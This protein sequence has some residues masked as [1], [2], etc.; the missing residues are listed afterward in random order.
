MTLPV[1]ATS[2]PLTGLDSFIQAVDSRSLSALVARHHDASESQVRSVVLDYGRALFSE[3]DSTPATD[4]ISPLCPVYL[5][6]GELCHVILMQAGISDL[7]LPPGKH[8][9]P[10]S[11]GSSILQC[12]SI[13]TTTNSTSPSPGYLQLETSVAN[14]LRTLVPNA[15]SK[16]LIFIPLCHARHWGLIV[17]TL[18]MGDNARVRA[19]VQW[20]DSLRRGAPPGVLHVVQS[21]VKKAYSISLC[22][23]D[24]TVDYMLDVHKF[25]QQTDSFASGFYVIAL[26]SMIAYSTRYIPRRS[27]HTYNLE[28]IEDIRDACTA[29]LLHHMYALHLQRPSDAC[30]VRHRDVFEYLLRCGVDCHQ[31]AR[32]RPQGNVSLSN[33]E[34]YNA[35]SLQ[36]PENADSIHFVSK[37][38]LSAADVPHNPVV[39]QDAENPDHSD[40]T[41]N[42]NTI[43]DSG[44]HD[45]DVADAANEP[46]PTDAADDIDG[47]GDADGGG[48]VDDGEKPKVTELVHDIVNHYQRLASQGFFFGNTSHQ[49]LKGRSGRG[50]LYRAYIQLRCIKYPG[51]RRRNIP[52]CKAKLRYDKLRESDGWH[53]S[54]F[55]EHSHPPLPEKL[56]SRR[57]N[58]VIQTLKDVQMWYLPRHLLPRPVPSPSN[59][60]EKSGED[61][62]PKAAE[63]ILPRP[64]HIIPNGQ[65]VRPIL[66]SHIHPSEPRPSVPAIQSHPGPQNIATQPSCT[67]LASQLPTHTIQSQHHPPRAV[68][69]PSAHLAPHLTSQPILTV[70]HS[71][72]LH[73]IHQPQSQSPHQV[74]ISSPHQ[75]RSAVPIAPRE[76]MHPS[77]FVHGIQM[78]TG[79]PH[80]TA[81]HPSQMVSHPIA[82]ISNNAQLPLNG[83]IVSLPQSTPNLNGSIPGSDLSGFHNSNTPNLIPVHPSGR[84]HPGKD[85]GQNPNL[86]NIS[87]D[88]QGL[89][90]VDGTDADGEITAAEGANEV[91][92]ESIPEPMDDI[93][94]LS[95]EDLVPLRDGGASLALVEAI[96]AYV[97]TAHVKLAENEMAQH[98]KKIAEQCG[99]KLRIRRSMYHAGQENVFIKSATFECAH[100]VR[101]GC[102]FAFR[103][104]G[105]LKRRRS[106]DSSGG[107]SRSDDEEDAL[108]SQK[109][110]AVYTTTVQFLNQTHNHEH[111]HSLL[112]KHIRQPDLPKTPIRLARADGLTVGN[113]I[114]YVEKKHSF[115]VPRTPLRK[116]IISERHIKDPLAQQCN[117]L[118]SR[119]MTI[120]NELSNTFVHFAPEGRR[121]TL[122]RL[123]WSFPEWQDDYMRYGRVPGVY[124]DTA[125]LAEQLKLPLVAIN[126]RTNEGDTVTFFV[127]FIAEKS[128]ES[129]SWM[130]EQFKQCMS[131]GEAFSP[132]VVVVEDCQATITAVRKHFSSS[133]VFMDTCS[134]ATKEKENV[135]KFLANLDMSHLYEQ[136]SSRLSLLRGCRTHDDFMITRKSF[137]STFFSKLDGSNEQPSWYKR[138]YYD[139]KELVVY[140]FNRTCCGLRFL[141]D[142]ADRTRRFD[143]LHKL[144]VDK[145]LAES[146]EIPEL[147]R[148][149]VSARKEAEAAK[150]REIDTD[151]VRALSDLKL[152]GNVNSDQC[153]LQLAQ[154]FTGFCIQYLRKSCLHLSD[155]WEVRSCRAEI[156]R[157]GQ[158]QNIK[159]ASFQVVRS[160]DAIN[161]DEVSLANYDREV[162]VSR[163]NNSESV[164]F[165]FLCSCGFSKMNGLPCAH[166]LIVFRTFND[167]TN[168]DVKAVRTHLGTTSLP[169]SSFIHEY[170]KRD[171]SGWMDMISAVRNESRGNQQADEYSDDRVASTSRIRAT[172]QARKQEWQT[173]LTYVGNKAVFD[174]AWAAVEVL[175]QDKKEMFHSTLWQLVALCRQRRVPDAKK[176]A[177]ACRSN[178]VGR[179][180]TGGGALDNLIGMRDGSAETSEVGRGEKRVLSNG[181][182]SLP[183]RRRIDNENVDGSS[184]TDFG[185]FGPSGIFQNEL[186]RLEDEGG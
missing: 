10:P 18:V 67:P 59:G 114:R 26:L 170:W 127:S 181:L 103:L 54:L 34:A 14:S 45:D 123:C 25:A 141:F 121:K 146:C 150:R 46:E 134:L 172:L 71:Q 138:L 43:S 56:R 93:F 2:A 13:D 129:F 167:E 74:P 39:P 16:T 102:L 15:A 126:G 128:G 143:N 118:A 142:G 175:E 152:W 61:Q 96:R 49:G 116:K 122:S 124:I 36:Q 30:A 89:E 158:S 92:F 83:P 5:N 77:S 78:P 1:G 58:Q 145:P 8:I 186:G 160:E 22:T 164:K 81:L 50:Q 156:D 4:L 171:N 176:L 87:E 84:L 40:P 105:H 76:T 57:E 115:M 119:L 162:L 85:D 183:Q 52:K 95:G 41:A 27:L 106:T 100:K 161:D 62:E 125:E 184:G 75:H 185:T 37:D 163:E 20:G 101:N 23:A 168:E 79:A 173:H 31:I 110:R 144:I 169:M 29:S 80:T 64:P 182:E 98:I 28:Y 60:R 3:Q 82:S 136:M 88:R 113:V 33:L 179:I 157:A 9:L 133:W 109:K 178:G 65:S 90:D 24:D 6:R 55:A 130:L 44:N 66:M 72:T 159:T 53:A 151:A 47:T 135:T 35:E 19:V 86:P 38:N 7:N 148:E 17:I 108:L 174:K 120:K 140:C 42:I 73:S 177:A 51:D 117:A 91:E 149:A 70:Q 12:A 166:Q 97:G 21:V 112:R 153:A 48:S 147:L 94:K 107:H 104:R 32:S 165:E 137:E 180:V 154:T 111:D 99:Y 139:E 131:R 69:H 155:K 11:L 68:H 132:K 63:K